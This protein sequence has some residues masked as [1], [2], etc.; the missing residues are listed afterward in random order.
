MIKTENLCKTYP[1]K[2]KGTIALKNI[3]LSFPSTSLVVLSGSSGSGKTTLLNIL[4]GMD[5][6]SGGCFS[7]CG[8]KIESNAADSYRR[9]NV[10]FVF[11]DYNLI[12]E[13]SIKN[14][15]KMAFEI[16]GRKPN[17]ELIAHYLAL[18]GLPDENESIDELLSKKPNEL[19]GGQRQRVAISRALIKEPSVLLLDEPTGSLDKDNSIRLLELLKEISK[20]RLVLL[21]THDL[22]VA[23]PYADR[24]ISLKSGEVVND[25]T[26]NNPDEKETDE[27][28]KEKGSPW[29][30]FICSL[31]T[32]IRGMLKNPIRLVSSIILSSLACGALGVALSLNVADEGK[33]AIRTQ[34][35]QSNKKFFFIGSSSERL[36]N[37]ETKKSECGFSTQQREKIASFNGGNEPIYLSKSGIQY[38]RSSV[39]GR[40]SFNSESPY[41]RFLFTSYDYVMEIDEKANEENG[42][43]VRSELLNE[44]TICR[45]PNNYE[46]IALTDM[47][48]DYLYRYGY[49][50]TET[51]EEV[52]FRSFDE[53][54][55]CKI[56]GLSITGIFKTE[57]NIMDWF[58]LDDL[59]P[60]KGKDIDSKEMRLAA[61]YSPGKY[62][63]AKPG[64]SKEKG[65]QPTLAMLR[66]SGN[67]ENELSLRSSLSYDDNNIHYYCYLAGRYSGFSSRI[68]I[69][70]DFAKVVIFG[71]VTCFVI[72][73][74][75]LSLNFFHT[76]IKEMERELGIM[77]ALGAKK[78]STISTVFTQGAIIAIIEF[79]LSL[80]VCLIGSLIFNLELSISILELSAIP[81]LG[82][83]AL[84][85]LTMLIVSS[86][87]SLRAL[88]K[89]PIDIIEN[90]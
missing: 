49:Y 54:I 58:A 48:A 30:S 25:K 77:K 62:L 82:M 29:Y 13:A 68:A 39:I 19:S 15:L 64:F 50:N 87:S 33:V 4:G 38:D 70:N 67:L 1:N 81:L 27:G 75:I 89:K 34:Y 10:G 20:K 6:P 17:D 51:K 80:I 61:G 84:I 5:S 85:V 37:G 71:I 11:Q 59:T 76:N 41:A 79:I 12:N 72:V 46:E 83:L 45:L 22:D 18:V 66:L 53:I 60:S 9:K 8:S 57:E 24:I 86:F 40:S 47:Q 43:L 23:K 44:S 78:S 55:G 90:K 42:V 14:N 35:E 7:F 2:G 52:L 16:D 32:A 69:I 36:E 56:D 3:S 73:G 21:S 63:I 31:K 28:N 65:K 88:T 74:M 26:I